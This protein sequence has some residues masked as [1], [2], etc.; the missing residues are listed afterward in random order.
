M[1]NKAEML[2]RSFIAR[3][4][5]YLFTLSHFVSVMHHTFTMLN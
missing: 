4:Y 5:V 1:L 2:S 3:L